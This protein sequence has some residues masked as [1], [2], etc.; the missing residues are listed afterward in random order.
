MPLIRANGTEPN[1]D[2]SGPTG[3]PVLALSNSLGTTLAMWDGVAAHLRGR[4]RILRYDTRGHGASPARDAETR[5]EDLANDLIGLLAGIGIEKA[6]LVG[7]SLGGMTVQAVAAK[8]PERVL[9]L[10]L[11]ATA[12]HLPSRES[13]R[14]RAFT[15]R[16]QGTGAVVEANRRHQSM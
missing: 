11:L 14:E 8:A 12:A 3:A 13:W 15:V 1:Y 10:S 6:H 16:T 5:I 2:L 9:S 7:L 4:F